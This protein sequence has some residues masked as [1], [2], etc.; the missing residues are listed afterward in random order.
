MSWACWPILSR[1][2][3]RSKP[4][5]PALDHEQR[6]ALVA[7][8]RVGPRHDHDQVGEDAVGDEG[9]LAVE[10][11]MVAL[12][13]GGGADPLQVRAR[14]GLGHRDRRDQLAGAQ[15][16]EPALLLLVGRRRA[17]VGDDHVVEERVRRAVHPAP[18]HLLVDHH[19]VA[20]VVGAA[21]AVLLVELECEQALRAGLGPRVPVDD[22]VGLPLLVPR[23]DLLVEEGADR[24][25]EGLVLVVEDRSPGRTHAVFSL[26]GAWLSA[27]SI[28]A[29][30]RS[31]RR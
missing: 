9:L 13:G 23:H 20:E 29:G 1:L 25:A 10:Q 15:A 19:V 18:G 2:R 3:P 11:V 8:V 4:S 31:S 17:E 16:G 30:P 22:A 26:V 27:S 5:M 21:A 12:V 14:A 6:D 7:G 24:V 28:E